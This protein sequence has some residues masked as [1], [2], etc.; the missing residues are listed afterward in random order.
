MHQAI[1]D[2][3]EKT[4]GT[5]DYRHVPE[6][7][8]TK[9]HLW[10]A[11]VFKQQDNLMQG[12]YHVTNPNKLTKLWTRAT[13]QEGIAEGLTE[14]DKKSRDRTTKIVEKARH[15]LERVFKKNKDQGKR[16]TVSWEADRDKAETKKKELS[17]GA[18]KPVRRKVVVIK[19]EPKNIRRKGRTLIISQDYVN[20]RQLRANKAKALS[21]APIEDQNWQPTN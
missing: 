1:R 13:Q 15:W 20:K 12:L 6:L 8:L 19:K 5:Q 14:G 7:A 16:K 17:R 3:K 4:K 9:L 2:L 18:E 11:Q 21:S 10:I